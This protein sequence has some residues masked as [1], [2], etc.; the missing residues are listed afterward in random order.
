MQGIK[1]TLANHMR[2]GRDM[3]RDVHGG[4]GTHDGLASGRVLLVG[5]TRDRPEGWPLGNARGVDGPISLSTVLSRHRAAHDV[6]DDV[7]LPVN[8]LD[9]DPQAA[10]DQIV[11]LTAHASRHILVVA[12]TGEARTKLDTLHAMLQARRSGGIANIMR[13]EQTHGHLDRLIIVKRR[14]GH[15]LLVAGPSAAGK[16]SLM[17]SL[18]MPM[19]S[20]GQCR[21]VYEEAARAVAE[22]LNIKPGRDWLPR[23]CSKHLHEE[24]NPEVDRLLLQYDFS[25]AEQQHW[26]RKQPDPVLDVIE[27][28]SRA[29]AITLW[30]PQDRLSEQARKRARKKVLRHI[31]KGS[32]K[33]R[34]YADP[35]YIHAMYHHYFCAIQDRVDDHHIIEVDS[36]VR[37]HEPEAMLEIEAPAA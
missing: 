34:T 13:V 4:P 19:R 31:V 21:S 33:A 25:R 11:A 7:I 12:E 23:V 24:S 2:Q 20:D 1:R 36:Q 8:T 15:L 6:Q 35:A 22:R 28:A 10:A 37:F 30:T 18:V 32:R 17:K 3:Y 16:S 9:M 29:S 5:S 26:S 27:S 14:V